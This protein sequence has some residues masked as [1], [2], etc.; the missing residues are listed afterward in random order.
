MLWQNKY[1]NTYTH[2]FYEDVPV[3]LGVYYFFFFAIFIILTTYKFLSFRQTFVFKV[4][5]W[6]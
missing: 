5:S 6:T 4:N 2:I 1:Y 3:F